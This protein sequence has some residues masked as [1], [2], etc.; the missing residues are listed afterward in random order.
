MAHRTYSDTLALQVNLYPPATVADSDLSTL[1]GA[2]GT[3]TIHRE[4]ASI[5]TE[6]EERGGGHLRGRIWGTWSK[7]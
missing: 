7:I 1:Q 6:Q 2:V 3:L 4:D 5:K